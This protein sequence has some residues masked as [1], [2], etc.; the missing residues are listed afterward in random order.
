MAGHPEASLP[1]QM[2]SWA[3]LTG[4]YRLLNHPKVS[5]SDLLKPHYSQTL[6]EAG[7]HPVLL[8]VEDTSELNFTHHPATSGLGPIGDGKGRGLLLHSTLG[9]LPGQRRVVG[10]GYVQ[11][12]LRQP[13]AKK[14]LHWSRSPESLLWEQSAQAIGRPPE[15][16]LW[17]HVSDS[18]SD[19]FAYL[20]AC[21]QYDKH[22]LVRLFQNRVLSWEEDAAQVELAE[23]RKLLD[24][25]RSL[26][27]HPQSEYGVSVAA[28][29]PQPAREAQVV[30]AWAAVTIPTPVQAPAEVKSHAPLTAWVI[31]AWEPAPPEGV[32][33]LEWLLLSS[34]PVQTLQE[35]QEK[36]NWYTH[37]WLCEDFHQCLKTG[38][39]IEDSQLDDGAD[40]QKLLGFAAP[41][42]VRLLQIRQEARLLPETPAE[43]LVDPLMVA[44]L[45]RL[46]K[47]QTTQLSM[48]QFWL[49]VARLGGHLGRMRDGPPGWRTLWRGW[50]YLADLT[51]GAHL[52]QDSS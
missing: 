41:I 5:M 28:I 32:E 40:I 33:G 1:N 44:I 43:V 18:G 11:V 29:H 38:C 7:R 48:G 35:A 30:L 39:K 17:V 10:L 51:Y 13:K 3:A 8:W 47:I 37:R 31:R 14:R 20:A 16:V 27:S 34:L 24:Y 12:V 22:F 4:A 19:N 52:F 9:V 26:A 25:A 42:A 50:R 15:N 36:V 45:V 49:G 6:Q 21:R 46:L 2:Q 23:T